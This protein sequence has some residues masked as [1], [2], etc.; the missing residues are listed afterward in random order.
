MKLTGAE[1]T[2]ARLL[3]FANLQATDENWHSLYASDPSDRG[4]TLARFRK[5]ESMTLRASRLVGFPPSSDLSLPGEVSASPGELW[6]TFVSGLRRYGHPPT[7]GDV[8]EAKAK[9]F[10][11]E[12]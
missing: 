9:S 6:K 2:A 7:P 11:A 8:I 12:M 4:W 10:F 5:I 1:W 3:E